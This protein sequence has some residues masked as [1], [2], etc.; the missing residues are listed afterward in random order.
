MPNR[1]AT[2]T[3][4]VSAALSLWLAAPRACGAGLPAA[5][6][7]GSSNITSSSVTIY[8][9]INPNGATTSAYFELG[10]TTSY[11]RSTTTINAGSGSLP[12]TANANFSGLA[13][14]TLHHYRVVAYNSFGTN[15]GLDAT[16]TTLAGPSI[17]PTVTT[18]G[19]T[20]ITTSDVRI[21]GQ[22]NPNSAATTAYFELG[23]TTNYGMSTST[24]NAGSG[25]SP[26]SASADFHGLSPGTLYHYRV[27]A[28]NSFG[29]NF[30]ADATFTTLGGLVIAPTA[31][32]TNAL[33]PGHFVRLR[34]AAPAFGNV[35]NITAAEALLGLAASNSAVAFDAYDVGI[36]TVNYADFATSPS[37][38]GQL[39]LDRDIHA[40]P[41]N[42]A[43]ATDQNNY[44]M[45]ITGYIYIPQTGSWTFYVNSDEGFRLRMGAAND[46]VMEFAGTRTPAT[47]SGVV[48]VPSPGYY[49]YQL[50]YFEFTGGS[51]VEFFAGA[52]GQQTLYLVGD[53]FSTAPVY[54]DLELP[55]LNIASQASEVVLSWPLKSG[56]WTLQSNTN[57]ASAASWV[58]VSPAPVVTTGQYIVTNSANTPAQFYRLKLP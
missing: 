52:P 40:I 39:G 58:T 55:R 32:N 33:A 28:Y 11:G 16:F 10:T 49:H 44:A 9:Q 31:V 38:Q 48:S 37:P 53:P 1:F 26:V 29:T 6:T 5:T 35:T 22:I 41:G 47:S 2:I 25:S 56:T 46:I 13:A 7:L 30:G 34:Q 15:F 18:Q 43:P 51:E 50:T 27:V 36:S 8:G 23:A 42:T 12:A 21:N 3:V 24:L 54:H 57:L 14:N 19:A 45:E 20:N 17:P 4:A